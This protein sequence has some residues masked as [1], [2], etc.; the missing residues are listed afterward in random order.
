MA[1]AERDDDSILGSF[2]PACPIDPRRRVRWGL[3]KRNC[4]R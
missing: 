3:R 2:F 1:A 4:S